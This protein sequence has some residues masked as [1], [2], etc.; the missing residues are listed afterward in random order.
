MPAMPERFHMMIV[1]AAMMYYGI[2][3]AANEVYARGEK[4]YNKFYSK[5]STDQAPPI[6]GIGGFS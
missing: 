2:F 4:Y 1:Y 5:L 3:E 6:T